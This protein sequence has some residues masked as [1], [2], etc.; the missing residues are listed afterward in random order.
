MKKHLTLMAVVMMA[1]AASAVETTGAIT[2]QEILEEHKTL[3][4]EPRSD[5][6][7]DAAYWAQAVASRVKVTAYAQAGYTAKFQQKGDNYNSFE[8]KRV[9]L[10]VGANITKEFYAFF[11]H[12]FKSG[13]MQEYYMEYRP[14]RAAN[15][16]FGQSKIELSMENPMSPTVLESIG[17]MSQGVFWLCGA[18]PLMSN[19]S[20]RDLGLMMYGYVAGDK[21][22]YVLEVVNGGQINEKD[23]NNQ[24]NVIAKLEYYPTKRWRISASGQKGYGSAVARSVYNPTVSVG[25][26][27]R[28]DRYAVGAEWKSR[29]T[30]NDYNLNRCTTVRSEMIGGRDG[31]CHT[32]GAYASAAIPVAKRLDVVAMADY[33][34]YNTDAAAKKTNL[35]A[36]L[37]YWIHKK[38]RL[39]AQYTYTIKSD[40]AKVLDGQDNYSQLQAQVQVAF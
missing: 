15:F 8:M 40:A 32:F 24:K 20:G 35:M 27:Y 34:N 38:C 14:C 22:K 18:D 28:Q 19:G 30:G 6:D 11:M 25:D 2:D 17:P 29:T 3:M 21:L 5:A 31:G 10:M 39:Q 13:G 23:R 16:R 26:T 7:K 4:A 9:I 12:D 36:G 1:T 37:Q 33:F